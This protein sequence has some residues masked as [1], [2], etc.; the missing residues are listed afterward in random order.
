M[1]T[2]LAFRLRSRL[3]PWLSLRSFRQ[4]EVSRRYA[5]LANVAACNSDSLTVDQFRREAFHSQTPMVIKGC[6]GS[7]HL[8]SPA[9]LT[10]FDDTSSG[11]YGIAA[12]LS[13]STLG[14]LFPYEVYVPDASSAE[15]LDDFRRHLE[16]STISANLSDDIVL[17]CLDPVTTERDP[18]KTFF[19]I[20]ASF[21]LLLQALEFNEKQMRGRG[22]PLQLYIAQSSIADLPPKL[23]A[24]L[25]PPLIVR[26]AGKG[27]IYGSSIWLGTE[28]T[29][30]PLHRDPNPNLLL[31]LYGSKVI[32]L[33]SP[34]DGDEIFVEVQK[35]L[36]RQA[37]SRIRTTAMM[38]GKERE[39]LHD[40]IW[41]K[42]PFS[43]DAQIAEIGPEDGL[44][45]PKGWWHSVKSK[46]S[47]GQLN[48][49]ANWWFR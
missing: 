42:S 7:L 15:T 30:T 45:I 19:Q 22:P 27:D 24:G 47:E 11:S 21:G 33:M 25:P 40:L 4:I 12:D 43:D 5:S 39:L 14:R 17:Q 28:P 41:K 13:A 6:K 1:A 3:S 46:R 9:E 36:G 23:R 29:Y 34:Q 49:S 31:Q 48:A 2:I 38:E 16:S 32:R 8:S 37:S 20:Q 35:K 26:E 10:L 44:F 18:R